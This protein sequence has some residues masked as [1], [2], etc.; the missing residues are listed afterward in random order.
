M[1]YNNPTNERFLPNG[2]QAPIFAYQWHLISE[3]VP[4][5]QQPS[6]EIARFTKV[7]RDSIV[8]KDLFDE[9][10]QPQLAAT[11]Q[12]VLQLTSGPLDEPEDNV[13]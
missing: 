13:E 2:V 11:K 10:V 12:N 9:H 1:C 8:T 4:N 3:L 6:K 5:P 7:V